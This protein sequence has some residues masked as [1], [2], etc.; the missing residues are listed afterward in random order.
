MLQKKKR[1]QSYKIHRL[2]KNEHLN[3]ESLQFSK[4]VVT[5][6]FHLKK[7]GLVCNSKH[8]HCSNNT[9]HTMQAKLSF[10]IIM[11]KIV[12]QY[13]KEDFRGLTIDLGEKL[14]WL[15]WNCPRNHRNLGTSEHLSHLPNLDP[16]YGPNLSNFS[17][18]HSNQFSKWEFHK[19]MA[20]L[21]I[22]NKFQI[23]E[24][25]IFLA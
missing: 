24:V 9:V 25:L 18:C 10:L 19:S 1:L 16:F 5:S 4:G 21:I 14:K 8:P 17:G 20:V 2:K 11:E 23:L 13:N 15:S 3:D 12:S 7:Y 22:P 6:R